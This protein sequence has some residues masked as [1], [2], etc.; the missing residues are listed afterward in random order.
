V[1]SDRSD[2]LVVGGGV[3]G[4]ASALRLAKSGLRV[5]VFDDA[6]AMGTSFAAAGMLAPSAESTPEHHAFASQTLLALSKWDHFA[7]VLSEASGRQ[8]D[9]HRS[10]SLFVA[11]DASDRREMNRYFQVASSQGITSSAV[12]REA[13]S[14]L[15][16][17][18]NPRCADGI[19]APMDAFVE[20]DEVLAALLVGA[21]HCGVEF[22]ADRV[23]ECSSTPGEVT[24]TTLSGRHSAR[25]GIIATGVQEEP[26]AIL[27]TSRHKLRPVRGVTVRLQLAHGSPQPMIRGIVQGRT[28]YIIRRPDGSALI[29]ATSDESAIVHVEAA[30]VRRLLEDAT[31]IL[32]ELDEAAF[33][34]ARVG[35]RPASSDHLPFFELL[36]E[37][38][39]AW[40]SGH[41]RHGYLLAPLAAEA[42]VGFATER[43]S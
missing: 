11:W 24:A 43:C 39:W 41:F 34:E 7:G 4:L 42:A 38:P 27:A 31:T 37:G 33:V 14:A 16:E 19:H 30:A 9:V 12:S 18:I 40:S 13:H 20:P 22:V 3:I 25:C 6:P 2:V 21:R 26:L 32:P 29:G 10:G 35:L 23:I 1:S 36:D 8:V 17:G 15:F 5:T 28:I